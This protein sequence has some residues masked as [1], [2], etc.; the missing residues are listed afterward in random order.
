MMT[1]KDF[2]AIAGAINEVYSLPTHEVDRGQIALVAERIAN[3]LRAS[4]PRFNRDRFL[5]AALRVKEVA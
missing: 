1:R 4:N 5:D 3:V 2:V